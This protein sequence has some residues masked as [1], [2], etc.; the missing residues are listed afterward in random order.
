[1]KKNTLLFLFAAPFFA[2]L[3]LGVRVYY[4]AVVWRYPGPETYFFIKPAETFGSINSRLT[5][6]GIISSARLF[7]RYS[8]YTGVMNKFKSGRY[9]IKPNSNMMDIYN[10][11][12]NEKSLAMFF[13]VPEG[14][15][16]FEIGHM[17]EDAHITTYIEFIALCKD[18]SFVKKLGISGSTVEGYLYPESYDFAP[19]LP[20]EHV[21][22]SMVREFNKK[23]AQI[24][25]TSTGMT[26][27][28]I[29][30]LAS[31]V[32]KETGDKSERPMIAGVFLNRLKIHMRLQSDPPTIYGMFETYNGNIRRKDLMMKS[33]YNT[34]T[35][36]ALP[37]GPIAN[38]GLLSIEAVLNPAAHKYLYF[39]SAN[40]GT[41]IFSESYTKHQEAVD[42]WQKN[43]K[44]REGKSWRNKKADSPSTDAPAR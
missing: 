28:Q 42:K 43:A 14:K 15:N 16:M 30:T 19:G 1:M 22:K 2:I 4:S 13:T 31:M 37:V 35:V 38:P 29:V 33:D 44:N 39:V 25:F 6:E 23:T 9:R 32:E 18:P 20:A 24:N 5:N 36:K 8:Q 12:I 11:F 17:L 26:K 27:E 34:Y 40:E 10:T 41:H 21:I 7:H 3:L